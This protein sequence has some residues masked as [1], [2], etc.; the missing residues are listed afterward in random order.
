[1]KKVTL[2][3][4]IDYDLYQIA[5]E[6]NPGKISGMF[7]R[8]LREY[9]NTGVLDE[10]VSK[11]SLILKVEQLKEE[12]LKQNAKI[13]TQV[14]EIN[15]IIQET[16]FKENEIKEAEELRKKTCK[17]CGAIKD[18]E[19]LAHY[20]GICRNCFLSLDGSEVKKLMT[21]GREED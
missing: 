2:N 7:N 5:M 19:H 21:D 15:K 10:N 6:K 11:E 3:I 1:M 8:W 16:E 20:G 13:N 14:S 18:E 9:Y 12:Q 4:S 17:R